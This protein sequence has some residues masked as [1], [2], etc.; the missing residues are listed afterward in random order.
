MNRLEREPVE[1]DRGARLPPERPAHLEG[2]VELAASSPEVEARGLVLLPLPADADTE[3]EP[4]TRQ[5]VQRRGGFRE[6]D[7]AA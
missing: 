2:E 6:N 5:H 3:I 7:G 4:A 1:I